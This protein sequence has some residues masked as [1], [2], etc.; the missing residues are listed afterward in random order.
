M[1]L[2]S[3]GDLPVGAGRVKPSGEDYANV[4]WA[5]LPVYVDRVGVPRNHL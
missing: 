2:V 5:E 3:I 1:V 4:F